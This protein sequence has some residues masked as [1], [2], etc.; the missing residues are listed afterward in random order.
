MGLA[1]SLAGLR[2]TMKNGTETFEKEQSA[3]KQSNAV[4]TVSYFL[5]DF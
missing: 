2:S 3:F 4:L 1:A 5:L